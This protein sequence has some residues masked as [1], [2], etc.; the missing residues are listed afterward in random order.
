MRCVSN[1]AKTG[2]SWNNQSRVL[3]PEGNQAAS[4]RPSDQRQR[5]P[6]GWTCC[7]GNVA[8]WVD[9]GWQNGAVGDWQLL[10]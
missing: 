10:M 4:S 5:M 9:G 3:G 2:M 7:D 1:T 6:D 8:W